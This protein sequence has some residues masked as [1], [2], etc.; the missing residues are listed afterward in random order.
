MIGDASNRLARQNEQ[1]VNANR[2]LETCTHL[3]RKELER[4]V[5]LDRTCTDDGCFKSD[6]PETMKWRNYCARILPD[7]K[8]RIEKRIEFTK[9]QIAEIEADK[10]QSGGKIDAMNLSTMIDSMLRDWALPVGRSQEAFD[11]WRRDERAPAWGSIRTGLRKQKVRPEVLKGEALLFQVSRD[12]EQLSVKPFRVV[13]LRRSVLV[14]DPNV[15]VTQVFDTWGARSSKAGAAPPKIPAL[16]QVGA[17]GTSVPREVVADALGEN[18]HDAII[19]L[20]AAYAGKFASRK[21]QPA[22]REEL[23]DQVETLEYLEQMAQIDVDVMAATNKEQFEEK[24][25]NLSDLGR[26]QRSFGR[27]P[28]E[29]E[30]KTAMLASW[31]VGQVMHELQPDG[32]HRS[33]FQTIND[34]ADPPSGGHVGLMRDGLAILSAGLGFDASTI[35][36][37]AIAR[38][39]ATDTDYVKQT[40]TSGTFPK[41]QARRCLRFKRLSNKARSLS[42]TEFQL[43]INTERMLAS[44]SY[45]NQAADKMLDNPPDLPKALGL[46]DEAGKAAAAAA[47]GPAVAARQRIDSLQKT[48]SAELLSRLEVA[49]QLETAA[50]VIRTRHELGGGRDLGKIT[51]SYDTFLLLSRAMFDAGQYAKAVNQLF[52]RQV[53]L[54]MSDP[55][56]H[57]VVLNNELTGPVN[58]MLAEPSAQ[59]Q[60][61]VSAVRGRAKTDLVRLEGLSPE[62]GSVVAGAIAD[63]PRDYWSRQYALAEWVARLPVPLSPDQLALRNFIMSDQVQMAL[64]KAMVYGCAAPKTDLAPL[65][66][67]CREDTQRRLDEMAAS[68]YEIVEPRRWKKS[69]PTPKAD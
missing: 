61:I 10:A 62:R 41:C 33:I 22:V 13:N 2:S 47:L 65:A 55:K 63:A 59:G 66:G 52:P 37:N 48:G 46:I 17:T 56:L 42:D 29:H 38:A 16:A 54:A 24:L 4:D 14:V 8:D 57:V 31:V 58:V 44:Q 21:E 20:L 28:P 51:T 15:G 39:N 11:A 19:Q 43:A 40:L 45:L 25:H 67:R 50:R 3:S 53:P 68:A 7:N 64:L 27:A 60:M 30:I 32:V 36:Q 23:K 5:T 26:L 69:S 18:P 34:L 35:V 12:N 1:L 6:K 49:N 9:R